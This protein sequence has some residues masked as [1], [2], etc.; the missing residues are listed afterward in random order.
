MQ[1]NRELLHVHDRLPEVTAAWEAAS[2]ELEKM[3]S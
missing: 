2:T 3:E 1:I